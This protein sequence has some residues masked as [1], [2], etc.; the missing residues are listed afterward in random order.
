M[1]DVTMPAGSHHEHHPFLQHHFEDLGQQ[2]EASTL[3]MWMFLTTEILFFGGILMAYWLYRLMYPEAWA[4]GAAQQN[5]MYGGIN[6]IVLIVSSLTMALAV[7]NAQLGKQGATVAMLFATLVFGTAFLVVKGIEYHSHFSEGLL[8]G[9]WWSPMKSEHAAHVLKDHPELA[10]KLQLFMLFYWGMTGMH[11]LHMII[12]AGLLLWFI[13][14]AN[15]GHFGPEYYGP[16]EVMGLYWHFVDIVWIFLFPF[17][18]LIH[19]VHHHG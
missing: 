12:G 15:R 19:Q 14:R 4:L 13:W 1:S 5:T 8:P 17:L 18:Y 3:G 7:R 9:A 6:T 11:A 10:P 2:H 16:V